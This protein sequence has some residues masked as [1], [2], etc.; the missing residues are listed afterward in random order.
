MKYI[1]SL[2]ILFLSISIQAQETFEFIMTN[3]LFESPRDVIEKDNGNFLVTILS[4]NI[5]ENARPMIL[6]VSP[7]GE[8]IQNITIPYN[9]TLSYD[10]YRLQ[11]FGDTVVVIGQAWNMS[12]G[13]PWYCTLRSDNMSLIE[14]R[15]FWNTNPI[16]RLTD[17]QKIS[18]DRYAFVGHRSDTTSYFDGRIIIIDHQ[19]TLLNDKTYSVDSVFLPDAIL[20]KSDH[21]GFILKGGGG[22]IILLDNNIEVDT[23]IYAPY[24]FYDHLHLHNTMKRWDDSTHLISGTYTMLFGDDDKSIGIKKVRHANEVINDYVFGTPDSLEITAIN[25]S[26]DFLYPDK[27]YCGGWQREIEGE[28]FISELPGWLILSQLDEDLNPNWTRY[29]GGDAYYVMSGVLATRDGG[30]LIYGNRYDFTG[31]FEYDIYL[32]KVGPNGL[33]TSTEVPETGTSG[34]T[35]YPNPATHY[36]VF[37]TGVVGQYDLLIFDALGKVVLS[38]QIPNNHP[39]DIRHLP[40]GTYTYLLTQKNEIIGQGKWVKE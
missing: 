29:Y 4:Q 40:T 32:L 17:I 23:V 36:M 10:P 28:P 8:L 15:I 27:I 20:E 7:E 19:G 35:V 12:Q 18:G 14:S 26:L 30:C 11:M 1:I 38:Q 37:D 5:D 34:I 13:Y 3:L 31:I 33:L 9:D 24:G 22:E 25:Q 2:S 21:S 39:I 16:S 6:E